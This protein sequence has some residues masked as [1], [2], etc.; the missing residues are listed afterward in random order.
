V[1]ATELHVESESAMESPSWEQIECALLRMD[2]SKVTFVGVKGDRPDASITVGGGSD[3]KYVVCAT[4]D[5][6]RFFTAVNPQA[7]PGKILMVAAGQPSEF[8]L[9][10]CVDQA[11]ALRAL[12][13]FAWTG[14]LDKSVKWSNR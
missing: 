5:N 4:Y 7:T 1:F 11:A 6:L 14:E 13:T 3:G 10:K 9:E 12:R 2:G 8:D